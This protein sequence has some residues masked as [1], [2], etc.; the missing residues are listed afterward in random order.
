MYMVLREGATPIASYTRS[1]TLISL[2]RTANSNT[3]YGL[4]TTFLVRRT[5]TVRE[6]HR[7]DRRTDAIVISEADDNMN[8]VQVQRQPNGYGS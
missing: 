8:V 7:A 6:P 2:S 5:F 3:V 1:S 4:R